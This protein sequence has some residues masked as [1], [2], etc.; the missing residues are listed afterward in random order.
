MKKAF[1]EKVFNK[2]EEIKKNFE[3]DAS[4]DPNESKNFM[5]YLD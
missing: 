3:P 5:I 4:V 1:A 2:F